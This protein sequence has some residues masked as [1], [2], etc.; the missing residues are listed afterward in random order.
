MPA[1]HS[2]LHN[3]MIGHSEGGVLVRDVAQ[4]RPDLASGVITLESPNNGARV[5]NLSPS[6]LALIMLPFAQLLADAVGCQPNEPDLL[7]ATAEA[8]VTVG[9]PILA[10]SIDPSF[11]A[12]QDLKPNSTYLNT[13][14][15]HSESFVRVGIEA[16]SQRRWALYRLVG[17][18]H[19]VSN[20]DPRPVAAPLSV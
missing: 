12:K 2:T 8:V 17:D 9:S 11:P 6:E 14:N 4:Q 3:I 19:C 18:L 16:H 13:L 5:A 10:Y 20:N 15:S 7:C 1:Q